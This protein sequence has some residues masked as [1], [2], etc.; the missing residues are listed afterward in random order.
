MGLRGILDHD[1]PVLARECHDLVHV[2][3]QTVEVNGHDRSRAT[4][5]TAGRVLDVDVERRRI[6]VGED[7][8]GALVE[9]GL[10][11]RDERERRNDDFVA[12]TEPD[13]GEGNVQRGGSAVR[14]ETVPGADELGEFRFE[15]LHLGGAGA[16]EHT[17]VQHARDGCAVRRTEHGPAL[18]HRAVSLAPAAALARRLVTGHLRRRL[19]FRGGRRCRS[20]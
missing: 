12:P 13:G 19:S 16:G 17:A 10:R 18:L 9:H 3:R 11:R 7:W 1:E 6:H 2:R 8:R 20:A 15:R 14:G 4:R 5:H